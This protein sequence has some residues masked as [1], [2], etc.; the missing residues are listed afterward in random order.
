MLAIFDVLNIQ[1]AEIA[2][3]N[4]RHVGKRLSVKRL[5][6]AA[7]TVEP[8]DWYTVMRKAGAATLA[9]TVF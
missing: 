7:V 8:D 5:T 9:R 3:A 2:G 4:H 1:N 6:N